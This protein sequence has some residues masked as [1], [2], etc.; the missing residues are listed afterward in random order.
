MPSNESF[1]RRILGHAQFSVEVG[2][3][4]IPVFR[5]LPEFA[6]VGTLEGNHVFLRLVNED[7]K[8]FFHYLVGT[9]RNGHLYF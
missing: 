5:S 1:H 7:A 3:I 6:A 4:G 9:H 8:T 2:G